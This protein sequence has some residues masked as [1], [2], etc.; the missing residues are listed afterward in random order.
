MPIEDDREAGFEVNPDLKAVLL[1]AMAG[2]DHGAA[3][4]KAASDDFD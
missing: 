3:I 4:C 2:C 1:D